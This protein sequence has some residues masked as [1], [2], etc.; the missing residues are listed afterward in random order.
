MRPWGLRAKE[1]YEWLKPVLDG[2]LEAVLVESNERVIYA[3]HVYAALLGYDDPREII[4]QPIRDLIADHDVDRLVRFG[5]LRSHGQRAPSVYDFAACTKDGSEMRL[6][7]SVS[8]A[9]VDSRPCITTFA[10]PF[11]TGTGP[12]LR[13]EE[14]VAGPHLTLSPRERE[15]MMLILD[16]K[17]IKEIAL[18]L[19]I[20]QKTIATHRARLL[21]KMGLSGNRELFQYALRHGL[22]DWT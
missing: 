8:V 21:M 15:V 10:R 6:H 16:G 17:R 9:I 11:Y 2:A 7:A 3:N 1:T 13:S 12:V 19:A 14:P 20:S 5:Q 4:E 18:E 22:V